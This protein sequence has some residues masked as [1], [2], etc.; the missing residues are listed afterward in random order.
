MR[1]RQAEA[2]QRELAQ[3]NEHKALAAAAAEKEA[4]ETAQEREAET[5]AVLEFVE[6]K[7]FAAARPDGQEGGLGRDVTL[8]AAL[9]AALPFVEKSFTNQ[10]L[11]EA[12]LR[13][14]AGTIIHPPWACRRSPPNNSRGPVPSTPGTAAPNTP[15]HWGA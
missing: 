5:K 3:G 11:I 4:K 8:R 7:I 1:A 2:E 14:D 6:Q 10:P 12:R 15:T 9:E 13:I